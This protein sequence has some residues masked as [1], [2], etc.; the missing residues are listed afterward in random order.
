VPRFYLDSSAITKR[1]SR[2]EGTAGVVEVYRSAYAGRSTLCF[3]EWNIGEVLGVLQRKA[4]L[5]SRPRA[6]ATQKGRLHG[7][8]ATLTRLRSLELAAVGSRLLRESWP[9]AERHLLY[10]A[11]ALQVVT[12]Q[13]MRCDYLLSGDGNL[14]RAADAER[15]RALDPAADGARIRQLV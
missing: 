4:R 3:S 11:D 15:I 10:E 7:E 6:Y 8:V 9:V 2:E 1:Y 5:A 13:A 14:R 12:A